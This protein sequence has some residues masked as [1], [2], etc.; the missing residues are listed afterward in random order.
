MLVPLSFPK[1]SC[2]EKLF[3]LAYFIGDWALLNFYQINIW[4]KRAYLVFNDSSVK[5]ISLIRIFF[6]LNYWTFFSQPIR[7][8]FS[9]EF[10]SSSHNY[11]SR[12][13]RKEPTRLIQST[14]TRRGSCSH[15]WRP[16][17][18]LSAKITEGI[19]NHSPVVMC[20]EQRP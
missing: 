3:K 19:N 18:I 10:P 5:L 2:W 14:Q 17:N 7:F 12:G 16:V 15:F 6:L 8:P 13:R 1:L 4:I 9:F 11:K 20:A